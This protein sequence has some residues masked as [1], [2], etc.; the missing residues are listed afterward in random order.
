[1]KLPVAED[2]EIDGRPVL[3]LD[4]EEVKPKR[5]LRWA[6]DAIE[7]AELV[8]RRQELMRWRQESEAVIN[9]LAEHEQLCHV[10]VKPSSPFRLAGYPCAFARKPSGMP[11]VIVWT[12]DEQ[13]A[14]REAFYFKE[15]EDGPELE[16]RASRGRKWYA[17]GDTDCRIIEW[18]MKS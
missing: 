13:P 17:R 5:F 8:D 16:G 6:K 12:E 7:K 11:V 3:L 2:G 14:M 9:K 1:M 10:K 18:R 15:V 4:R